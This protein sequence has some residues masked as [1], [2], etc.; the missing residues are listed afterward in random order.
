MATILFSLTLAVLATS[1]AVTDEAPVVQL[2]VYI[3]TCC[4]S[5]QHFFNQSFYDAYHTPGWTDMTNVSFVPF[6][7]CNETM[8]FNSDLYA[9]SCQHG[10]WECQGN[11]WMACAI[12]K[13][14]HF[15]NAQYIPFLFNYMAATNYTVAHNNCTSTDAELNKISNAVCSETAGCDWTVLSGCYMDETERNQVYH[16]MSQR[17]HSDT[18]DLN[19]VPWIVRD[20]VHSEAEQQACEN[21]VLNCTCSVYK[22]DS[23]ACA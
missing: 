16:C 2:S 8:D 23:P 6:G 7:K 22:G 9:Y 20:G 14:Y 10:A 19:W 11:M 3:E 5:C 17:Q 21:D 4:Y 15:D 18:S 1:K 13:V 12:D